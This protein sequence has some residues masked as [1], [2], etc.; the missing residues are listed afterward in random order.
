MKKYI[1]ILLLLVYLALG[2][3]TEQQALTKFGRWNYKIAFSDG[4]IGYVYD[5]A[6]GSK[7]IVLCRDG[8]LI[9]IK[10]ISDS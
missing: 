3:M 9:E 1:A 8:W 2:I 7:F 10:P 4:S 6:Y 5:G